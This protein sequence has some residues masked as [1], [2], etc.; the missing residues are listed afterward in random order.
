MQDVHDQFNQNSEDRIKQQRQG[1]PGCPS[2]RASERYSSRN[3][4][5]SS[6]KVT[7]RRTEQAWRKQRGRRT[8]RRADRTS[9]EGDG[10][11]EEYE[12]RTREG[13]MG[14]AMSR[15]RYTSL[16]TQTGRQD[17]IAKIN[18]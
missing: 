3:P 12:E 13:E 17:K 11:L 5:R 16:F 10:E 8:G 6:G 4:G 18:Q 2:A 7:V 15:S 1:L 14:K 9:S